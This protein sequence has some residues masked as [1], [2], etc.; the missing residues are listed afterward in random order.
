MHVKYLLGAAALAISLPLAGQAAYAAS[1][2]PGMSDLPDMDQT[3]A[4]MERSMKACRADHQRWCSEFMPGGPRA[5][6][7]MLEHKADLQP[8]CLKAV[9]LLNALQACGPDLLRYCKGIQPGPDAMTCLEHRMDEL[10]PACQRVVKDEPP[11]IR[12]G[13]PAGPY[14]PGMR[15]DGEGA[16]QPEP[17][18]GPSQ[19]ETGDAQSAGR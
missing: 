14:S 13:G 9:K 5:V 4:A 16:P 18:G 1:E 17:G 8:S 7:C 2:A 3:I 12:Q 19:R 6:H 15:Q 11:S 10:R